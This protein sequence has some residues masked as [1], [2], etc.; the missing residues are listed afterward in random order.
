MNHSL[1]IQRYRMEKAR[2]H[3]CIY[4]LHRIPSLCDFFSSKMMAS[5]WV[6]CYKSKIILW[7]NPGWNYLG[8]RHYTRIILRIRAC[9][10]KCLN[11]IRKTRCNSYSEMKMLYIFNFALWTR[12]L[13]TLCQYWKKYRSL[14]FTYIDK[15]CVLQGHKEQLTNRIYEQ[16]IYCSQSRWVKSNTSLIQLKVIDRD[17]SSRENPGLFE[18]TQLV[19]EASKGMVLQYVR[20]HP[21]G[22]GVQNYGGHVGRQL[23]DG[24]TRIEW[25]TKPRRVGTA[26][27][28]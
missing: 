18:E 27:N 4:D 1:G 17:S 8:I 23:R 25:E 20:R 2:E 14:R 11:S 28:Q 19:T 24:I 21:F 6:R 12:K 10:A 5:S 13:D 9:N 16:K 15:Y 7:S 3:H 26:S 22:R